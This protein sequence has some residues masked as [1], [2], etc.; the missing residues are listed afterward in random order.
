MKP[1]L[2]C[3]VRSGDLDNTDFVLLFQVDSP[4]SVFTLFGIYRGPCTQAWVFDAIHGVGRHIDAGL[5]TR[6]PCALLEGH[7]DAGICGNRRMQ[8]LNRF[9]IDGFVQDR[10]NSSAPAIKLPQS[11]DHFVH[12]HSQ[13]GTTLHCNVVSHWLGAFTKWSLLSC[14]KPSDLSNPSAL[15]MELPQACSKPSSF[16]KYAYSCGYMLK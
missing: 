6:L 16:N 5:H 11:M 10:C 9:F 4:P 7:V 14:T 8:I 2:T 1:R 3:S 12:V 13:W 15:T